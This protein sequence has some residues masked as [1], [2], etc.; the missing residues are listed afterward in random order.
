MRR[1]LPH[2]MLSFAIAL[3]WVLLANDFSL[4]TLVLAAILALV[5]PAITAA[6]WPD[7]PRIRN[8]P[9]FVAYLLLVL[10][11]IVVANIEVAMIV[12]FKPDREIKSA[13][14]TVPIDLKHPEAVALLAGTITM[15]PGT[16]T[17]DMS[18]DGHALLVHSL[19]APDPDAVRDQIK[20]RYEA[21]LKR[22]FE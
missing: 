10:W 15:T 13:W 14:I 12:L 22:I 3:L 1:L 9:A 2:P 19:H 21:R 4:N 11:D 7:R 16:V 8:V 5:I 18:P 20:S 17:A 6:W